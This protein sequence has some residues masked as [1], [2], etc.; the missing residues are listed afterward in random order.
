L[1]ISNF[2][3]ADDNSEDYPRADLTMAV[4]PNCGTGQLLNM[5]DPDILYKK[6]WYYSGINQTM[7]DS[8]GEVVDS[9]LESIDYDEGDIFL[10]IASND[11]TLLGQVDPMLETVGID[12]ADEDIMRLARSRADII[13]NDYFSADVY[14]DAVGGRKA[15]FVTCLAMFYDLPNPNTFLQHVQMILDD[16]GLFVLQISYTPLMLEQLEFGN[17]CAEHVMYYSAN[18]LFNLCEDNGFNVVDCELNDVNGGSFRL[19]LTKSNGSPR[20]NYGA[21]HFKTQQERDV[22]EIRVASL[23][24]F[25]SATCNPSGDFHNFFNEISHLKTQTVDFIKAAVADGKTVYGYGASTKGNT[26]LQFFGLDNTLVTK[27]ADRNSAKWGLKTVGS[28]IPICSED[29]MR[30]DMPDYLLILPWHF[31]REFVERESDYIKSGGKM[32]FPCPRF[33]VVSNE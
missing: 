12:P 13:V 23:R 24:E 18:G 4:C 28:E 14:N 19:Y 3:P 33:D 1:Y 25:E 21:S 10:D 9:C 26:L 8:L 30:E 32:I 15:K 27:I 31:K 5:V 6:Y 11:G 2:I 22:G 7:Q 17:I 16:E 29:E 20:T